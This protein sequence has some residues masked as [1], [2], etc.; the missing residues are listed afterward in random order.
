VSKIITSQFSLHEELDKEA[1]IFG[2]PKER[3]DFYRGE[4][5]FETTNLSSRTNAYLSSQAFLVIA[6]ASS[7]ANLN[8]QWGAVFT[9]V[10]PVMLALF[11]VVSSLMAWPGIKAACDIIDHWY[12]K[13][14]GLLSSE[15]VMGLS[16]D[17]SPLFSSWESTDK[18]HKSALLFSKRT[19]WM[20]CLF[21]L[22]L[23][24]FAV[25]VHIV[26]PVIQP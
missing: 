14:S 7:M 11:G 25:F 12:Y 18:G 1:K 9:L 22:C 21:W 6:Y 26:Y 10:V 24:G 4:I 16:Y 17:D 13:Q 20:F 3:L 8:P 23:G 2:S 19:P 5:H 15:P